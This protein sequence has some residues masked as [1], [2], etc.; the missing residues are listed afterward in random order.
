M[1]NGD[2]KVTDIWTFGPGKY[3][4][5][6]VSNEK[7]ENNRYDISNYYFIGIS[8]EDLDDFKSPNIKEIIDRKL[9]EKIKEQNQIDDEYLNTHTI[10]YVKLPLDTP[11][12]IDRP[13]LVLNRRLHE[14]YVI[15]ANTNKR[16]SKRVKE[17]LDSVWNNEED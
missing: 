14:K 3:L 16:A 6:F 4:C 5:F 7:N 9:K 12:G 10:H 1:N 2:S 11:S 15:D 17:E 8:A 13:F